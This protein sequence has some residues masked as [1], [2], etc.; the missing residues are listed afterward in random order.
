M[1]STIFY[2]FSILFLAFNLLFLIATEHWAEIFLE[3]SIITSRSC[4]YVVIT[5]QAHD[6]LCEIIFP[7]HITLH[8]PTMNFIFHFITSHSASHILQCLFFSFWPSFLLPWVNH[9]STNLHHFLVHF[10]CFPNDDHSSPSAISSVLLW[11]NWPFNSELCFLCSN[12]H[13]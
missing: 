8:L 1:Y 13:P 4:F 2:F 5:R 3:L 7:L 6:F 10:S 9:I 11:E 12:Q